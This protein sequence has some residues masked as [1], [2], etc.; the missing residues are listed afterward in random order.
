MTEPPSLPQLS[1]HQAR[2]FALQ[3]LYQHQLTEEPAHEL[4]DDLREL[5]EEHR[6]DGVYFEQ[7]VAGVITHQSELDA[8]LSEIVQ[9]P[10]DQLSFVD[11]IV[12]RIASYEL[13]F[14]H[15]VPYKVV[16]NEALQLVKR[17]GSKEGFKF[18]NWAL[19]KLAFRLR[20]DEI[21]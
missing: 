8:R 20:A 7:L 13:M 1:R 5:V 3:A 10:L 14:S 18:L 16:L 12:M 2:R 4:I 21:P 9:H 6:A 19:E 11:F 15:D 17:F